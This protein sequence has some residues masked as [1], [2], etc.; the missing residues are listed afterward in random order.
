[1]MVLS[2]RIQALENGLKSIGASCNV[3]RVDDSIDSIASAME[4]SMQVLA[5]QGAPSLDFSNVR[6]KGSRIAT[7]GT[8]SGAVSFM[9][10]FDSILSVMRRTEK[11]NSAGIVYLDYSHP[12]LDDFLAAPLKHAYKGVYVPMH[13]TP[14]AD[15]LLSNTKMM[16]KLAA[17]YDGF[18]CFLVKRPLNNLLTNLCTEVEIPHKGTCILASFNLASY[19][20]LDHFFH[21]F[22][23]DFAAACE[24]LVGYM[25]Q[26]LAAARGTKLECTDPQNRQVGMGL[27]G[28]ASALA[29]YGITYAELANSFS[30]VFFDTTAF[31]TTA[32]LSD[33]HSVIDVF[34]AATSFLDLSQPSDAFVYALV[35]GY[36]VAT[37]TIGSKVHRAFCIQ[38][39]VSTAQRSYD[40][41][42]YHASPEIQPVLG[43]KHNA[44]VSTIVKSAIKGDARID[45][46]PQTETIYEVPYETY[47]EVS[48]Y[49]QR[50]FNSTGLAHRHSH[51]FYDREFTVDHLRKF[52][53]HPLHSE[54]KSL[55]YRL[56]WQ[57]N[58]EA[59][60]KS[61]LWQSTD[62]IFDEDL[63][64]FLSQCAITIED[65]S[66][67]CQN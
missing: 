40:S 48:S 11:K 22:P 32:R 55:Y 26:S 15:A 9:E 20:N 39:T 53:E 47:S 35:K 28:L 64:S 8:S 36:Y 54:I 1:M 30:K 56:P 4:W 10:P 24:T 17:A 5:Y 43:L 59:M 60:D 3:F 67:E 29:I 18:N 12:E 62:G 34:Y 66:C 44:A 16:E 46:H 6:A 13:G 45:Y 61:Q 65:A 51:C 49:F 31:D 37:F 38:P 52:Y 7:G 42:S 63:D 25:N 23:N 27:F 33:E 14:E 50:L 19:P 58:P 21:S 2:S 41:Q 57:V